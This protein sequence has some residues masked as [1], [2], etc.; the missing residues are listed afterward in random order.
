MASN[1]KI[2]LDQI[3]QQKHKDIAQSIS[4]SD[5][6][7]IFTAEQVLK[8]YDLSYDDIQSGIV[9]GGGDGGIDSI[10]LFV[11]EDLAREDTDFST[12]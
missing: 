3:L 11:N 5:Y 1:D 10:F 12:L 4:A 9:G 2:I 7:E 8:D 6:F